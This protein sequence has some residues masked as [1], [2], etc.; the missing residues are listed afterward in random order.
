MEQEFVCSVQSEGQSLELTEQIKKVSLFPAWDIEADGTGRV[1][2]GDRCPGPSG[3]LGNSV[4]C[5]FHDGMTSQKTRAKK[6]LEASCVRC[7]HEA[8]TVKAEKRPGRKEVMRD[9]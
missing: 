8:N 1:D 3:F 5:E 4:N 2:A 6:L 7:W 9:L